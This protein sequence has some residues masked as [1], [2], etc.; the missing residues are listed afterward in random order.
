MEIDI[1]WA[2]VNRLKEAELKVFNLY[3]NFKIDIRTL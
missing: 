1:L 2:V 3:S